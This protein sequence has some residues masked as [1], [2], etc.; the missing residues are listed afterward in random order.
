MHTLCC[1]FTIISVD[2]RQRRSKYCLFR[3]ALQ[4]TT[5]FMP[6]C[7]WSLHNKLNHTYPGLFDDRNW[8]RNHK[9]FYS[10]YRMIFWICTL[11]LTTY[12]VCI[13]SFNTNVETTQYFCS[14]SFIWNTALYLSL[15]LGQS[16]HANILYE[17]SLVKF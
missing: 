2:Q 13:L 7:P 3:L 16:G 12:S 9:T 17:V 10:T 4:W 6:V 11:C 1:C 8:E 5:T 15:K 14:N